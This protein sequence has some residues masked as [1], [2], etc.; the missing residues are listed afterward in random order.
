MS[1]VIKNRTIRINIIISIIT[2]LLFEV[3]ILNLEKKPAIVLIEK[4]MLN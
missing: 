1:I 3:L 2:I 4:Y